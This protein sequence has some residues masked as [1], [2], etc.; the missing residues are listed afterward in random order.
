MYI[1]TSSLVFE[2]L[3]NKS[4]NFHDFPVFYSRQSFIRNSL[5]LKSL[6]YFAPQTSN[7]RVHHS[8]LQLW[9]AVT[10]FDFLASNLKPFV[11][12]WLLF[13]KIFILERFLVLEC[14]KIVF[15]VL[16]MWFLQTFYYS[17]RK[18]PFKR[19]RWKIDGAGRGGSLS[20]LTYSCTP[21]YI[22]GMS[23]T[24]MTWNLRNVRVCHIAKSLRS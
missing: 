16:D 17:Y 3:I 12:V 21:C 24:S 15:K 2:V 4:P 20:P 11:E 13:S 19:S 8:K 22:N 9:F 10:G 14:S 7:Y 18:I 5:L 6:R 1:W 23:W